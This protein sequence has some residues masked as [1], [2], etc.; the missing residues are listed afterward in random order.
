[1]KILVTGGA[2]F[3][4]SHVLEKL[5]RDKSNTIT[6]LDSLDSGRAENIPLGM[7]FI[8]EDIRSSKI[9]DI[10]QENA[11]DAVIHLA[12]QTMVPYSIKHPNEDADINLIGLINV[13]EA[14]RL[15]GVKSVVFSSSAAVYGNSVNLPLKE[16]EILVPTSFYGI[17]KMTTEH[18]LRVYH[19]LYGINT[20]VLRFANVYGERQ[21]IGGEG[22]VVCIFSQKISNNQSIDVFGDGEQTRDFVYVKDIAKVICGAI[23]HKGFGT[24][25]VST[26]TE[27]AVNELIGVFEKVSGKKIKV[28]YL[29]VRTG[30]IYR[31]VLSNKA[32]KTEFKIDAFT[33]L[34]EGLNNTYN[35][36]VNSGR[37]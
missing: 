14:A 19:E 18:Y 11:F 31:S 16:N 32:L 25:N 23:E 22:G 15:T 35:Y 20:T 5:A 29:P 37:K 2:G 33:S 10:F 28:N 34:E 6:V 27:V 26:N 9:I 17:T 12:A 1:M 21:G 36:F 30:D 24:Y 7:S 4:G 13:L 3:I 8:R